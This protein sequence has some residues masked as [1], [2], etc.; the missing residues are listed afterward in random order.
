MIWNGVS[1]GGCL[2]A[3]LS[4]H[5]ADVQLAQACPWGTVWLT[6][7]LRHLGLPYNHLEDCCD[8]CG[9]APPVDK[10]TPV[11]KPYVAP[12]PAPSAPPSDQQAID[13]APLPPP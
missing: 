11:P 10:P 3:R 7:N 9:V 1:N 2:V 8:P 6:T 13:V 5:P 4:P 12:A